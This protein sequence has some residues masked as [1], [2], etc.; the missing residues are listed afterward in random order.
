MAVSKMESISAG[1]RIRRW[2]LWGLAFAF[3]WVV[4]RKLPEIRSLVNTLLQGKPEWV[5]L[6]I[7]T[8][9]VYF[10]VFA[11]SY[12]EAFSTVGVK[13]K[14]LELIPVMFG[15]L[16]VNVVAPSG[17]AAGAA[18]F[19]DDAK[20]RGESPVHATAGTLLQ[21]IADY[22]AFTFLLAGG[23]LFLLFQHDL[24]AY[25]LAGSV[26]LF[27]M[28]L[29]L[30]AV[31]LIALVR[32]GLLKQLL[33]WFQDS[34]D[35]IL[36]RFK[37]PNADG[38]RTSFFDDDWVEKTASEFGQ[39][40]AAIASNP[41][42]LGLTLS[43]TFAAHL[44]DMLSLYVLFLAFD[45]PVRL[46]VLL[47]GYAVGIL[48]WIVS[49]TP[50]GIGVVEGV[51]IVVYTSLGI[52]SEVATVVVLSF[53]GLSF[54]L[55]L[56]L[57]FVFLQR[58]QTFRSRRRGLADLWN[59][60]MVAIFTALMGVINVI[61]AVTPSL[62]A[63]LDILREWAP[64]LV[65]HGGHLT[66]A[67]SGFFLLLLAGGLW[68]HKHVAWL[69][70]IIVLIVSV[71]SNTVKGLDYEEALM[72]AGL[73]VWLWL[74]RPHFR[75]RSDAPSIRQGVR[76]LIAA[77]VFTL[78]YGVVGF[79]LLDHHYQINFGLL[80]ALRQTVVMFTQFYDPGLAPV[81]RFGRYF[82][83]SIYIVGAVTFSYA[84]FM[85]IQPVIIRNTATAK[86]HDQAEKIIE[87]YGRSTLARLTLLS[88]KSY[89]FTPGG[90]VVAYVARGRAAIS[91]G[92]PI[93]PYEDIT[94]AIAGFK[95]YC[96]RNDW[97]TAFYQVL[98]DYLSAYQDNGFDYLCVGHEAIVD[99]STF[100]LEG[101]SNKGLRSGVNRLNRLGYRSELLEPPLSNTII[102]DLRSIS[103]EWLE[104][105][106]GSEKRFSFGWFEE[107]YIRN[108]RVM[109]IRDPDGS[110]V[111]FTNV[112]PEYKRNEVSIDLMRH[113]KIAPG[114]TMDYLFAT[115]FE[116]AR[117]QG[118]ASFNLGLSAL[119]G[120]GEH[121]DDPVIERALHYVYE[122]INQ[123][124]NFK[125]LHEFKE[126]FHP[127]WSP[128]YLVYPG[129]GNLAGVALALSQASK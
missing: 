106:H 52:P 10:V 44:L 29:G 62:P 80:A 40:S 57:G 9:G 127:Q 24:R 12:R 76:V 25:E 85:L 45:S 86:E 41:A 65:R 11:A 56:L 119:S 60:R 8:Q 13:S 108:S 63:R 33:T 84:L 70:T 16:F 4:I 51:M 14:L 54:W 122:N 125:G 105:V 34:L 28:T 103:D 26:V 90:S 97:D 121:S 111:A 79:Y 101:R 73:A 81:T 20:R 107:N 38:S 1:Y 89:Y 114:G 69:L 94:N 72:S 83:G 18:L 23:L 99:L 2:M 53:R 92:D 78:G 88:D 27:A 49:I 64:L 22:A 37:R 48:F 15:S 96:D 95:E 47:A 109:V 115:L 74:L 77:V 129:A 58:V 50:Q 35:R 55:P 46:G 43:A 118:Y 6:A 36:G 61:S 75:A 116:W 82:A 104:H 59:V 39:A 67:L 110:I 113:R 32:P 68:R 117:E 120:I 31:L 30:G 91:L 100:T 124:Y 87:S 102:E 21:L 126:K 5:A 66:A 71:A 3:L 42:R 98:P 19:V 123:F 112:L 128:R 17:G 7:V 93:G